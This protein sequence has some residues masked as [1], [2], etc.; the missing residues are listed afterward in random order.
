MR[1]KT[2]KIA[3][4]LCTAAIVLSF[5][6]CGETESVSTP[7]DAQIKPSTQLT[8]ATEKPDGTPVFML[9]KLPE[10]GEYVD[11]I[12]CKRRYTETRDTLTP[13]ENYGKL[14]P[15]VGSFR[16]YHFVDYETGEWEEETYSVSKYGLMTDKGEI[17][18][19]AVY[20][21]VNIN[22][23]NNGNYSLELSMNGEE[24]ET[25]GKKIISTSDGSLIKESEGPVSFNLSSLNDGLIIVTDSSE[26]D[27]ENSAGAPKTIFY[28]TEWNKLFEFE[29]SHPHSNYSEGYIVL[30]F[31][32]D[33]FNYEYE[34][35]F[36]DKNGNLAFDGVYPKENFENGKAP[37]SNSNGKYGLFSSDGKWIVAPIYDELHKNGNYYIAVND[38]SRI[39]YDSEGKKVEIISNSILGNQYIC[40]YGDR[41]YLE[42]S[43]Y[44]E[45]AEKYY[46]EFTLVPEYKKIVCKE[47][48]RAVTSYIYDTEYFYSNDGVNTYVVNFDGTTVATLEGIG[49]LNKIDN[50]H[51][52]FREGSWEDETQDYSVYTFNGFKKLWSDKLKNTGN[53]VEIWSNEGYMVKSYSTEG[54]EGELI[55][56]RTY[57][58]LETETGKPIFESLS[59]YWSYNINGETYFCVSDGTYTYTYAPDMTLLMKVRNET[60][61]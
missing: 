61:D 3:A 52:E 54:N 38:F 29:N 6:G 53:R 27:W 34:T 14:I 10:I 33:Y 51:F 8:T 12:I 30:D 56:N 17:V 21:W 25:V 35:H 43:L 58:I 7:T 15:F 13:G 45:E 47:T 37:A 42:H 39:I 36:V 2:K 44:D 18:V 24:F 48:G 50:E 16:D 1:K 55:L 9:E 11:D 31:F 26:V 57:D 22:N 40:T 28:D 60:N 41:I 59:D 32:S 4:L 5:T 23:E 46:S 19:D 49:T 20:D